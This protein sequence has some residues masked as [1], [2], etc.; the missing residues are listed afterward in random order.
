MPLESEPLI[1]GD[2]PPMPESFKQENSRRSK[3]SA[4]LPSKDKKK[5]SALTDP[6]EKK[7]LKE[8]KKKKNDKD[9]RVSRRVTISAQKRKL[10]IPRKKKNLEGEESDTVLVPNFQFP[11]HMILRR[12]LILR[13]IRMGGLPA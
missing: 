4:A 1:I 10:T 3:A 9:E 6:G 5:K 8:G 12:L 2:I 7:V 11:R 13:S